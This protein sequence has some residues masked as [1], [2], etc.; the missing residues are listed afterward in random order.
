MPPWSAKGM[1]ACGVAAV[2]AA[3]AEPSDTTASVPQ[4][5]AA[6]RELTLLISTSP[7]GNKVFMTLDGAT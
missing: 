7:V 3:N 2:S 6:T 5:R 1:E 4:A